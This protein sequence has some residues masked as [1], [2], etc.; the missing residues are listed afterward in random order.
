MLDLELA[1]SEQNLHT[2][3]VTDNVTECNDW[4]T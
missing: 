2:T 3:W 1:A 4:G